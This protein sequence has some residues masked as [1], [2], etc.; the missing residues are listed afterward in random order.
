[1]DHI[2]SNPEEEENV[3]GL[4]PDVRHPNSITRFLTLP[5]V[6]QHSMP[7]SKDLVVNFARSIILM[8]DEYVAAATHLKETRE[9]AVKEK[10]QNKV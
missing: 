6:T 8:S 1:V 2:C 3:G 10:E 4:D 5:M 9:K 7:N